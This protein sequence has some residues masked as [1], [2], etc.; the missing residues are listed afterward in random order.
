MS[1]DGDGVD[2]VDGFEADPDPL[3]ERGREVLADEV[4]AD[5]QLAVAAVDQHGELHGPGP[6]HLGQRVERGPDRAAG[7]EHVVDQHHG[8]AVDAAGR[9]VGRH[10]G[11][12][13]LEA[14]VVA[15]HRHVE[16]PDR[17][18]DALDRGHPLGDALGERDA[19]RRDP[20]Q[21]QVVGAA[22]ALEDLVRDAGQGPGDVT[23]V[24]DGAGVVR[25]AGTCCR[26][27]AH[28][29]PDLLLRLTGRLV[30]GCR[31]GVTLQPVPRV[32]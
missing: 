2:P 13:R 28:V 15:V 27:G 16:R 6:A 7:V 10:Q 9:D 11:P 14:Q 22:V 4:G 24:E 29:R 5:R 30:K 8:L 31:S 19:A 3:G 17:D 1:R 12:G 21:H 26:L 32:V 25:L 18:R 20:E 23:G